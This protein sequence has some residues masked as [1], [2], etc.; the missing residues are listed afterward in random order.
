MVVRWTR[1][2]SWMLGR[3][4]GTLAPLDMYCRSERLM[5]RLGDSEADW[6]VVDEEG[7]SSPGEGSRTVCMYS[8]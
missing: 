3:L 8:T 7:H 2:F 6:D 4:V 1:V 5:R